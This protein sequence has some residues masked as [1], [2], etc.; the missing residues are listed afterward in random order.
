VGL[1][2][3]IGKLSKIS[4]SENALWYAAMVCFVIVLAYLIVVR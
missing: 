2:M 4:M 1:V 3:P